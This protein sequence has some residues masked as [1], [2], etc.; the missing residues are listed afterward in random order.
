MTRTDRLLLAVLAAVGLVLPT[1]RRATAPPPVRA[2]V[3][4]WMPIPT[5]TH[6]YRTPT[7][8]PPEPTATVF[9]MPITVVWPTPTP[10]EAPRW[11]PYIALSEGMTEQ[12]AIEW[13]EGKGQ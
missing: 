13:L 5:P 7:P 12:E 6:W 11:T 9:C 4:V 3:A 8:R 10:T 2:E 1:L